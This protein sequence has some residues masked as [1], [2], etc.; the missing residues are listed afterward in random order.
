MS[1]AGLAT[2]RDK[3]PAPGAVSCRRRLR[4]ST[5]SASVPRPVRTEVAGRSRLLQGTDGPARASLVDA[6]SHAPL[7]NRP[8]ICIFTDH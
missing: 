6:G 5:G 1:R 8:K 4:P 7:V 3:V 2:N